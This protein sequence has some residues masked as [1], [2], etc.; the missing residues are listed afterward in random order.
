MWRDILGRMECDESV[1]RDYINNF[2]Q[3]IQPESVTY[4]YIVIFN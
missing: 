3:T 4:D 2:K 1:T